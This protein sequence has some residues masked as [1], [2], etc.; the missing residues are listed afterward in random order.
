MYI[1]KSVEAAKEQPEVKDIIAGNYEPVV[2][3]KIEFG[4][5]SCEVRQKV[6][7]LLVLGITPRVVAKLAPEFPT[8]PTIC[9]WLRDKKLRSEIEVIEQM[10]VDDVYARYILYTDADNY[11]TTIETQKGTMPNNA[12]VSAIKSAADSAKWLLERRDP[13]RFADISMRPVEFSFDKSRD[14]VSQIND[15]IEAASNAVISINDAN[16]IIDMIAKKL[17]IAEIPKI[18]EM[19]RRHEELLTSQSSETNSSRF[20][21]N[22]QPVKTQ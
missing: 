12:A 1:A 8:H 22:L 16:R 20:R 17:E 7:S 6:Y 15:I 18:I 13:R 2:E 4:K 10:M 21:V 14:T 3:A 9:K 5:I 11:Q 19:V